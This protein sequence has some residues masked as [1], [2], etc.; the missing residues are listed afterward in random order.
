MLQFKL[1]LPDPLPGQKDSAGE[2]MLEYA[3]RNSFAQLGVFQAGAIGAPVSYVRATYHAVHT[4][5]VTDA[6]GL[7]RHVRF[8][9]QPV[10]GVRVKDPIKDPVID[11]YLR[12]EL[13]ERLKQWPARMMLMM[14][15]G[16]A[17]DA[18]QDSTRPWPAKRIRVVMGT[19]TLTNLAADQAAAAEHIAFNPCRFVDGIE[20]SEDPILRARRG[21]YE[22][23][24]ERRGGTACPFNG[25]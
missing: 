13:E 12:Q 10:A 11:D 18:F 20:A 25:S 19:L 9:W 2:G 14:T 15:I 4:F 8:S 21:A 16:E 3:N 17:G 1:P 23:S 24:R 6:D 22:N 7:R 5:V